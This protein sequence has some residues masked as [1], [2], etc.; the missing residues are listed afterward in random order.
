MGKFLKK[1]IIS[2]FSLLLLSCSE[3]F[4]KLPVSGSNGENGAALIADKISAPVDLTATHGKKGTI[5]LQWK[6][7]KGAVKYEIFSAESPFSEFKKSG[8]TRDNFFEFKTVA[9]TCLFG[10]LS[11]LCKI[12]IEGQ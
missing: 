7:V 5:S 9:T 3:E 1:F 4:L 12:K 10:L 8:E 2:A 6:S 11:K